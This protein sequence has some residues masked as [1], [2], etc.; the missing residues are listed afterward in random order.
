M[1]ILLVT[2]LVAAGLAASVATPLDVEE[3]RSIGALA[4]HIA[5]AFEDITE[6]HAAPDGSYLVFDRRAHAVYGV[7]A[8]APAPIKLLQI[9]AETGRI[10]QPIA[11]DSAPDGTLVVADAPDGV[12]RIQFFSHTGT[13][14]G[15]FT[16][17][18]S[19]TP[20]ITL[21]DLV[22]S[23]IG[24]VE[25][26]GKSI[27]LS[28]PDVGALVTEYTITGS[29]LR[30]FGALRATGHETD[31]AVHRAHNVGLPLANPKGGFYYVFVSGVPM[32]RKYDAQGQL[33]FERH[34]EGVELDDYVKTLPTTWPRRTGRRGEFPIVPTTI[35][36]AAV[37]ADG[38]L[39]ISL[40]VPFTYVYDTAGD[41][42][43]TLQFRGA[44][45]INPTSFFFT[46]DRR[47]L[48]TPGCYAFSATPRPPRP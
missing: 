32:F 16:I 18:R 42:R 15:G 9:G 25:F 23:G 30:T 41:K 17:G 29:V 35:R 6:C 13:A 46:R 27:L 21:G 22:I 37:D 8:G 1:R 38:Q 36:T 2:M 34:I 24:S 43:R 39:W 28:Q 19:D 14:M 11:F 3:L 44:G 20:Q 4:P 31:P 48:V 33:I 10:L 47:V 12:Q 7:P 45:P 40:A 5:G 26:T